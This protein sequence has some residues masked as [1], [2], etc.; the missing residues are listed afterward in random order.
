VS[1]PASGGGR[2]GGSQRGR[3]GAE[4]AEAGMPWLAVDWLGAGSEGVG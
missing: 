2:Q 4:D 1:Q 3:E